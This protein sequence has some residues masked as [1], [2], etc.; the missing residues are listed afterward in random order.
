MVISNNIQIL[1]ISETHLDDSFEDGALSI[2]GYNIYRKDRNC[3]GVCYWDAAID[4]YRPPSSDSNYLDNMC[5]IIEKACDENR[6]IYLLG[7]VNLSSDYSLKNRLMVGN[8]C[9]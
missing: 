1:A 2:Q 3:Y 9:M 4:H 7:D 6:E 8:K 5:E